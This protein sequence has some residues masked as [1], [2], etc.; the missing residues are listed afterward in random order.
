[1]Q[2]QPEILLKTAIESTPDGLCIF[3]A[4]LRVLVSNSHFAEMY[5][6]APAETRPG[7]ALRDIL[8]R[9]VA[10]SYCPPD[11]AQYIAD[12]YRQYF[13]LV[14]G[15]PHPLVGGRVQIGWKPILLSP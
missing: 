8:D 4:D 5:G 10:T 6:L 13:T 14:N 9:R 15:V 7:T 3:D 12:C 11:A 1:M 2:T